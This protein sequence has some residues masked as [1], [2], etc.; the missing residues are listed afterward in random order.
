MEIILNFWEEQEYKWPH[1]YKYY[2]DAC[3]F[4][5]LIAK[6]ISSPLFQIFEWTG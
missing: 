5:Y 1:G 4:V 6:F 3:A 2:T